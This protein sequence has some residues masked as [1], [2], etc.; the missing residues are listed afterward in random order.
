MSAL[1][2]T[3]AV[4]IFMMGMISEQISQMRFERREPRSRGG[5]DLS[6]RK[7]EN[8]KEEN[9]GGIQSGRNL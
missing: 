7:E 5:S 9:D 1:L 2:F 3:T 8:D 6:R 4:V